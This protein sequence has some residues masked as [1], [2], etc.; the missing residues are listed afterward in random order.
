MEERVEH[1]S[2]SVC[3]SLLHEKQFFHWGFCISYVH[4]RQEKKTKQRTKEVIKK[5]LLMF[6]MMKYQSRVAGDRL[7]RVHCW[8]R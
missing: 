3:R 2:L 8:R 4:S 6:T 1:S 5:S 7:G